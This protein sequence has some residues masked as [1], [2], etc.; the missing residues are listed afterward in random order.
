MA[1]RYVIT[2]DGIHVRKTIILWDMSAEMLPIKSFPS[3]ILHLQSN[4]LQDTAV[5][6]MVQQLQMSL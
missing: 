4:T 5:I 3:H 2:M 1:P 6:K